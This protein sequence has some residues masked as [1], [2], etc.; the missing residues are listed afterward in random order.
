MNR[1]KPMIKDRL[2]LYAAVV[3]AIICVSG[4]S[5]YSDTATASKT[6]AAA[7][8]SIAH[9]MLDMEQGAGAN[10]SHHAIV[11]SLLAKAKGSIAPKKEYSTNDAIALL[12]SID[13]FLKREG[14]VFQNNYLL[15]RALET[16]KIDCDGYSALYTAIAEALPLPII[17]V[18]APNHSFVRFYFSDGSYLNWEPTM[19]KSLPDAWYVKELK[20]DP[21]SVRKG[22]YLASLSRGEFVGVQCNNIGGFFLSKRSYA[23]SI[24]YFD[25]AIRQYPRFSSAYHNRG[26][27]YYAMKNIPAAQRDLMKAYELDPNRTS[28]HNTLGD[29]FFDLKEYDSALRHYTASIR[30][31]PGDFVPYNNIAMIFKETGREDMFRK[32]LQKSQEIKAKSGQK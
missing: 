1:I 21:G 20:I 6:G 5:G 22:V 3:F 23:E 31:N 30:L 26:T 11:D 29:L 27:A 15:S 8:R 28:T 2:F 32:W 4:L 17:P 12:G 14:F 7:H 18:Y 24:P 19:A 10:Q 9:I 16:K 13:L 25:R